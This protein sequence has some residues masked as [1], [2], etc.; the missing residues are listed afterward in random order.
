MVVRR[1]FDF[2]DL[3]SVYSF[4]VLV[5][6]DWCR[7][8]IDSIDSMSRPQYAKPELAK[9][10]FEA[11]EYQVLAKTT[12]GGLTEKMGLEEDELWKVLTVLGNGSV[13]E[14]VE[15][16]DEE[17]VE[18]MFMDQN[19]LWSQHESR[20]VTAIDIEGLAE[21]ADESGGRIVPGVGYNPNR[22]R[23]SLDRVERAVDELDFRYVW[24]H[25][26]SWGLKPTDE[27]C[28]PLYSKCDELGVPV[29]IQTGQSAEPLTSEPGHPIYADEVA[30]DFP[31]LE[32]ILT[33][34][35]W[36]WT[37]EWCSM[38][39][40]HPNVYGN[41]GAYYPNHMPD[42]Q[43]DFIDSGRIRDKVL[44][45]TN[46]LD[47]GRHKQEFLDLDIRGE[48]KERVLRENALELFDL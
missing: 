9:D 23:E 22:I 19:M 37:G 47:I 17:G 41:I 21:M 8:Q 1:V 18:Y 38:L 46:G 32:L 7:M 34:T 3:R 20:L 33:H 31:E 16:M 25:P 2:E 42:D 27:K 26:M 36:P 11:Y 29:A 45:A 4:I 14:T 24:F 43:V 30:I 15:E 48:T 28:Y 44:W 35:G 39:W 13:E 10:L 12:F 5:L 6:V 40:R